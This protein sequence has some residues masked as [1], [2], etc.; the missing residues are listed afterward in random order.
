M[1]HHKKYKLNIEILGEGTFSRIV[2][3]AECGEMAKDEARK[4]G[5]GQITKNLVCW[6]KESDT[7]PKS[8]RKPL[9]DFKERGD[10]HS[11]PQ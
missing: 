1:L 9:E 3:K 7:Y 2:V 10:M 8:Y 5:K 6:Q 11:L 4:V